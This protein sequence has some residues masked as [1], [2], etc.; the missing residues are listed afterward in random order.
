MPSRDG[1]QAIVL[2]PAGSVYREPAVFY[3][4]QRMKGLP[5]CRPAQHQTVEW[6]FG[7]GLPTTPIRG[8]SMPG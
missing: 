3:T 1:Q 4:L 5:L 7:R 8:R 2:G 6:A